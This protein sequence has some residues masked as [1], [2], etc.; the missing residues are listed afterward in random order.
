M[1]RL[2]R[3]HLFEF[4]D[5][6][7]FPQVFRNALTAYL[8]AL[9]RWSKP[10]HAVHPLI[11]EAIRQ[12]GGETVIDLCTGDGISA[13]ALRESALAGGLRL[14]WVLTDFYPNSRQPSPGSESPPIDVEYLERP[15]DACAPLMHCAGKPFRTVFT[16]FH[17]FGPSD[18]KSILQNA[19]D[20]GS[21]IAVA[22]FTHRSIGNCAKYLLAPALACLVMT[23]IRP[24]RWDWLFFSFVIPVLPFMIAWDGLV[25]NLRTY[26]PDELRD[27]VQSVS[28]HEQFRWEIG[29][30]RGSRM[31]PTITYL[32]AT[33]VAA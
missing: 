24:I 2:P 1:A 6:S 30:A 14:R 33:R 7:W 23:T 26:L 11:L 29:I 21:G 13:L 31:F 15:I 4:N 5:L 17:H 10:Y 25:S 18:A 27:L 19:V 32:I 12:S 16:A 22:E 9:E 8:G 20:A 28:E 3:C